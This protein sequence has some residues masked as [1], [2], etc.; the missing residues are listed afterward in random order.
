MLVRDKILGIED[1]V[2]EQ[3][4]NRAFYFHNRNPAD[5]DLAINFS[6]GKN[7]SAGREALNI[8]AAAYSKELS[9][10]LAQYRNMP[11][12]CSFFLKGTCNRG[13]FCPYSHDALAEAESNRT[14]IMNRYF[15]RKDAVA[16]KIMA[17]LK[18]LHLPPA[19]FDKS[20]TSIALHDLD[21]QVVGESELREK[22]AGFGDIG[23]VVIVREQRIG[24]VNFLK[25]DAADSA[26]GAFLD[27][28]IEVNGCKMR[29]TWAFSKAK[30]LERDYSQP[31]L[32]SKRP[33]L[34]NASKLEETEPSTAGNSSASAI[35]YS[36]MQRNQLGAAPPKRRFISKH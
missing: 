16:E 25:R 3:E 1:D 5:R 17:N 11:F 30:G 14:K 29:V 8:I 27:A 33:E 35:K 26:V 22:F 13:T 4:A 15:G 28:P 12:V 10:D 7:G 31:S 34:Q 21:W 36:S 9:Q 2:P 32:E 24:F 23:S 6:V 19:L 20:I 18:E